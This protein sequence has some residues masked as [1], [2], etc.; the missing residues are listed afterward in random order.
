M[1]ITLDSN[2]PIS[3]ATQGALNNK[4]PQASPTFTGTVAG[5]TK[6]TVGLGN[7]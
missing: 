7:V 5:I 2:K 6:S 4:A 3:S 1:S